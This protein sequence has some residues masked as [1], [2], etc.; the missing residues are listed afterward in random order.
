MCW[1]EH[2][3]AYFYQCLSNFLGSIN[4]VLMVLR[5]CIEALREN[6]KSGANKVCI[7]YYEGISMCYQV[8]TYL[9]DLS[10]N[11]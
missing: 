8:C 6:Q 5:G 4:Q 3:V 9:K 7:V 2:F 1:E 11:T 10:M